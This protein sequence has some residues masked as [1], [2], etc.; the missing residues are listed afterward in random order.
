MPQASYQIAAAAATVLEAHGF[1][2]FLIGGAVRDLW[3]GQQPKDFDLVTDATPVQISRIRQ[4]TAARYKDTSQAY[5][6]TRVM[7]KGTELE[8][9]TFRRDLEAHRGRKATRIAFAD[10][11]DDV[12]RRDFT[13]NGL[14]LDMS[15]A[16]IIDYVGGIDDLTLGL[17][18]FIGRPTQRLREDPLRLLRAIRFR[19]QLAFRY[20][21][22]TARAIRQAVAARAVESIATDRLRN[23]L[24]IMLLHPSRRQSLL[25]LDRFGILE[26]VVPEVTAG[27]GVAQP[28]EFHAEGDVWKHQLLIMDRLP[29]RPSRQLVWA[30]LLH[31]IGKPPTSRQPEQPGGRIRFDR[32]YA[33]GAE[34]AKT[35]LRRLKFSNRDIRTITWLIYH[36]LSAD[37]L[38]MMRPSHQ[39]LLLGHQAFGDLLA[40][41]L[42]DAKASRRAGPPPAFPELERLWREYRAKPPHRRQPSLK[43]DVGIDGNWLMAEIGLAPGPMLG[44]LLAELNDWYRDEGVTDP[45]AYRRRASELLNAS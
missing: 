27:R 21:P 19:N 40:L 12:L 5:G 28:P 14:A 6:V 13:I 3:L 24:T 36:H 7:F 35:V 45:A 39:Q 16:T 38:P 15:T 23:E 37:D 8:M 42:A 2:A 29:P 32:H 26:R 41:H 17:I 9:A 43:R 1:A 10:L 4:L 22:A 30:A 33:V 20:H 34:L 44:R 25:D 31:D 18:R 11:E